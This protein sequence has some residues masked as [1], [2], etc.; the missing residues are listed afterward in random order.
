MTA[1]RL[2]AVGALALVLAPAALGASPVTNLTP[3]SI[4]G[5]ALVGHVLTVSQGTWSGSP[6]SFLYQWVRCAGICDPTGGYAPIGP[7]STKNTYRL[8]KAD[9]G[10]QIYALVQASNA[11]SH[12]V[13]TA[14]PSADVA[15]ANGTAPPATTG[16]TTTYPTATTP[17]A[18]PPPFVS[19]QATAAGGTAESFSAASSFA[20]APAQKIK[21]V[22]WGFGDGKTGSG[23]HTMH[24]YA[25]PGRYKVTLTVK[26]NLDH[27]GSSTLVVHVA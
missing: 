9:A 25:R 17:V 10:H 27:S 12:A 24:R 23:L 15:E 14:L 21:S 11:T 18:Y 5:N 7:P 19:I 16:S 4:T 22:R 20:R 3:P 6:T 26:D 1:R 13:A 2:A 8:T